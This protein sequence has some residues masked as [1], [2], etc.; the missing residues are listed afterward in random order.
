MVSRY[1]K[2]VFI[3]GLIATL[4]VLIGAMIRGNLPTNIW[5]FRCSA[6]GYQSS[7]Y[8]SYCGD[9]AYGDYEHIALIAPLE[10][11]AV[12][13]LK[14][15]DVLFLGNSKAKRAFNGDAT[16][17]YFKT[18]D[19]AAYNLGFGYGEYD[20][21]PLALIKKYQLRPK[22]LIIN[23]DYFFYNALSTAA[24]SAIHA[25]DVDSGFVSLKRRVQHI[26]QDWCGA[27]DE[28]FLADII[29]TGGAT[30]MFRSRINGQTVYRNLDVTTAYP[31]QIDEQPPISNS[32]FYIENA[33]RFLAQVSTPRS[34]IF[35]TV[36]PS[37]KTDKRIAQL[38]SEALQIPYI[39][40]AVTPYITYDGNHLQPESAVRWA[41]E[42]LRKADRQIST[43]LSAP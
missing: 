25:A 26:H 5:I 22:V 35:L 39:D 24:K 9:Q 18:R 13:Y 12:E 38:V 15:A 2:I 10:P 36:V 31:A 6:D 29:C 43:C 3:G 40:T 32:A 16:Y 11:A 4:S 27:I 14:K 20:L 21:F 41:N 1:L 8:L 33:R 7:Y 23:A 28:N 42:F 19:A 37:I 17:R 34:C 30:T